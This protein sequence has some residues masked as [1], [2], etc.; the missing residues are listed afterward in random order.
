MSP[1]S[2]SVRAADEEQLG[3]DSLRGEAL[4]QRAQR[5]GNPF[6]AEQLHALELSN[7]T[8]AGVAAQ[9]PGQPSR[10]LGEWNA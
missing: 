4:V 1:V 10:F 5:F 8:L 6:S 3:P 2:S 7:E 9:S